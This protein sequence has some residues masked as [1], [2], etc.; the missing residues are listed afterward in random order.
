MEKDRFRL[1]HHCEQVIEYSMLDLEMLTTSKL[2]G[3]IMLLMH[4]EYN[5]VQELIDNQAVQKITKFMNKI[6][7]DKLEYNR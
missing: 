7:S 3:M 4:V 5:D 6:E 1:D 2:K